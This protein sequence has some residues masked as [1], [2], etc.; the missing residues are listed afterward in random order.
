MTRPLY[1][2]DG[3]TRMPDVL[4]VS[5]NGPYAD[6]WHYFPETSAQV[7]D[8]IGAL[9]LS[10]EITA[11]VEGGLAQPGAGRLLVT[12]GNPTDQRPHELMEGA[13]TGIED[14]LASGGALL[15]VL[16][17]NITDHG[18]RGPRGDCSRRPHRRGPELAGCQ[19]FER[20]LVFQFGRVEPP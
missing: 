8:I 14:H 13:R 19:Q 6:A 7:A 2:L 3:M 11:D 15:G 18:F 4:L 1:P 12:I 17:R 20:G 16:Q 10:V 9:G 5:G